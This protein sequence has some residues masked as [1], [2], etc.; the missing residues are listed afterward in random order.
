MGQ[1]SSEAN[2]S[3]STREISHFLWNPKFH[4]RVHKSPPP[5]SLL[6]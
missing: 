3:S 2:G 5:K 4:S 6:S 1:N